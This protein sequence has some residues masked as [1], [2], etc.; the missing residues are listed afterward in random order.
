MI[1]EKGGGKGHTGIGIEGDGVF[2]FLGRVFSAGVKG[3]FV[4]SFRRGLIY[5]STNEREYKAREGERRAD[6]LI[7][8]REEGKGSYYL[9]SDVPT[10]DAK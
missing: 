3:Y 9:R 4:P 6:S 8:R 5:L 10:R 7:V 1:K 2:C